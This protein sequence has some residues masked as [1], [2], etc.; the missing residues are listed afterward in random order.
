MKAI[1]NNCD[2][3]LRRASTGDVPA[4][5]TLVNSAYKELS[6]MGLNYTATDQ[7]EEKTLER[8]NKGIAFVLLKESEI[9]ATI[10][11]SEENHFTKR[12]TA[13]ISQFAVNPSLKKSGLGT[14]LMNYCEDLALQKKYHG[15]QLDTAIPAK[16]LVQWYQKRGYDIV[17]ETHWEGKTYRSYIFEKSFN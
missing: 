8:I 13:Y 9:V 6:D 5:R 7:N 2:Y 17:G 3:F 10:L 14:F 12:H 4:L 15:V 11:F 16:H 1:I